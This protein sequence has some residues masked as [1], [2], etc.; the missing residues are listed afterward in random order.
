M[1]WGTAPT[2]IGGGVHAPGSRHVVRFAPWSEA[3]TARA[4]EQLVVRDR[5]LSEGIPLVGN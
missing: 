1:A 3:E 4:N 5:D 2:R